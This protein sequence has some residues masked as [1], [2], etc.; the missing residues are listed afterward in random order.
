MDDTFFQAVAP[1][2]DKRIDT[3][4]LREPDDGYLKEFNHILDEQFGIKVTNLSGHH[5]G[6]SKA[7]PGPWRPKTGFRETH[8]GK[9]IKYEAATGHAFEFYVGSNSKMY[10]Q[11]EYDWCLYIDQ[12]RFKIDV[13]DP[14]HPQF[15]EH[16]V[17]QGE[18]TPGDNF[19]DTDWFP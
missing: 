16:F 11:G 19:H 8:W 10:M 17:V 3:S 6:F 7:L 5:I 14:F 1:R 13:S 18:V 12:V 15:E 4:N 2:A 9:L